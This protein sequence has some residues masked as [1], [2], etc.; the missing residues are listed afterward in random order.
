MGMKATP[1]LLKAA[2]ATRREGGTDS[3]SHR[4]QHRPHSCGLIDDSWRKAGFPQTVRVTGR[5][6]KNCTPRSGRGLCKGGSE[7]SRFPIPPTAI[8]VPVVVAGHLMYSHFRKA[9]DLRN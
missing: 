6:V 1:G 8:E 2:N 3:R 7:W 5:F 9:L 4:H